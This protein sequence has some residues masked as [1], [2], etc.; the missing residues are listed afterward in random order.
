M[1]TLKVLTANRL[2]DGVAVWLGAD[3]AWHETLDAAFVARHD[4]AL[5]GL[6]DAE[7]IAAFDQQIVD[8]ALIDVD[9]EAGQIRPSRLRERIR[10]AGPTVRADLGK[11]AEESMQREEETPAIAA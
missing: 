9:D 10:A 7:A 11:Q 2:S 4:A 1:S 3:G 8:V 6:K 5:D